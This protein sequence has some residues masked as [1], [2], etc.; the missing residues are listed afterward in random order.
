MRIE[1]ADA[2]QCFVVRNYG[3][4]AV[5]F[6]HHTDY[7]GGHHLGRI[8]LGLFVGPT[9]QVDT[10]VT[11]DTP[12]MT[13]LVLLPGMDGTGSLFD[14]LVEALA[15]KV[16]VEVVRYPSAPPAGYSVLER[17][18]E[19]SL[20][21][22]GPLI[23]LGESFS[24]PIAISLA[25]NHPGRVMGLILCCTFVR[26]PYPGLSLLKNLT[27]LAPVKVVPTRLAA[28]LLLGRFETPKLRAALGSALAGVS[29]TALRSRLKAVLSVDVA[30]DFGRVSAP[31]LYLRASE[32][33]VVPASAGDII[34]AI[35]PAARVVQISGPHCL[36]QAAPTEAARAIQQF[37]Q[38]VG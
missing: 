9:S 7:L 22:E 23:L 4:P 20:P 18:A 6:G 37:V 26:N 14:P 16:Q 11:L 25:A 2:Q 32:D 38:A 15:G 21:A 28:A 13:A 30:S 5:A 19:A 34:R 1:R 24:G 29:A 8:C 27:G 12:F 35:Q 31:I 33:R 36:L 17:L 3:D 10:A